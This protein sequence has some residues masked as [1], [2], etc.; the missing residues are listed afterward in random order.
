MKNRYQDLL[1]FHC[2]D[3]QSF[4]GYIASVIPKFSFVKNVKIYVSEEY[5]IFLVSDDYTW[6]S[7]DIEVEIVLDMVHISEDLVEFLSHY[8]IIRL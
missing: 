5:N 8:N 2:D 1:I 4:Q 6:L 7:K 3:V